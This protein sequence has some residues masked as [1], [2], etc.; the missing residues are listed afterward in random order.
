MLCGYT[1]YMLNQPTTITELSS[2]ARTPRPAQATLLGRVGVWDVYTRASGDDQELLAI[3][4][5]IKCRRP[6]TFANA[7]VFA[8]RRNGS[9]FWAACLALV[10]AN[11]QVLGQRAKPRRLLRNTRNAVAVP[12][13]SPAD[14]V[15]VR[16]HLRRKPRR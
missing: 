7:R 3:N 10:D 14:M 11:Y 5:V 4:T 16:E 9:E 1:V 12:A 6:M 8:G 2:I 15:L 13:D